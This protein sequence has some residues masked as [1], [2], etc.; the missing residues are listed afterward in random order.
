MNADFATEGPVTFYQLTEG[1]GLL[2]GITW[3]SG[4]QL[5]L[6][7]CKEGLGGGKGGGGMTKI[8]ASK[9][10]SLEYYKAI[11]GIRLILF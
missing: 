11:K 10:R 3:F 6:T 7:E 4:E 2:W 5:S 9:G 1:G 8:T